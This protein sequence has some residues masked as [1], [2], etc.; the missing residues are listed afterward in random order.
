MGV[1]RVFIPCQTAFPDPLGRCPPLPTPQLG[2]CLPLGRCLGHLLVPVVVLIKGTLIKP[3][4]AKPQG[5]MGDARSCGRGRG[6]GASLLILGGEG[7]SLPSPQA[8]VPP[9]FQLCWGKQQVSASVRCRLDVW[10][11]SRVEKGSGTWERLGEE[12]GGDVR[13]RIGVCVPGERKAM[14]LPMGH[15][16]AVAMQVTKLRGGYHW[17]A[18]AGC[19]ESMAACRS[20]STGAC[21]DSRQ[22]QSHWSCRSGCDGS[23]ATGVNPV[24]SSVGCLCS[25]PWGRWHGDV[26]QAGKRTVLQQ[27]HPLGPENAAAP[28]ILGARSLPEPGSPCPAPAVLNWELKE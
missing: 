24:T 28:G 12:Q 22:L 23:K 16:P 14:S 8:F 3:T 15:N 20:R 1:Y 6:R 18:L 5:T 4:M 21:V 9:S 11:G 17:A 27:P 7:P 26:G 13:I 2:T 10:V 25:L 19:P